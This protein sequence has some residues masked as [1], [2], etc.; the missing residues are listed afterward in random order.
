M[1]FKQ[2]VLTKVPNELILYCL[3]T[4]NRFSD[5]FKTPIPRC[6]VN[7]VT[8]GAIYI[9]STT[10]ALDRKTVVK[11]CRFLKFLIVLILA[12]GGWFIY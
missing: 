3:K 4:N 7:L 2:L 9:A 8:L 11:F 1:K 10:H 12:V 6:K 5:Y